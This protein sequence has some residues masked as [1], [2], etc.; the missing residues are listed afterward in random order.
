MQPVGDNF[1]LKITST[2]VHKDLGSTANER[3][4]FT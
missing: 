4:F 3:Q 1:P 2:L